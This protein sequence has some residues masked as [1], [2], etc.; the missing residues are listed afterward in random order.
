MHAHTFAQFDVAAGSQTNFA[1][2]AIATYAK[3]EKNTRS[4]S[5]IA[6][7]D[8]V[9]SILSDSLIDGSALGPRCQN[10]ES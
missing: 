7:K 2:H 6:A 5:K 4:T 3:R 9:V 8:R 10:A 1:A